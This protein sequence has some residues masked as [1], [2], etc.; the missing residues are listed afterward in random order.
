MHLCNLCLGRM[1]HPLMEFH[2]G[3]GVWSLVLHKDHKV[4]TLFSFKQIVKLFI[5]V[6]HFFLLKECSIISFYFNYNRNRKIIRYKTSDEKK[7]PKNNGGE[8]LFF[9]ASYLGNYNDD[10][11]CIVL[12]IDN[13]YNYL[14]CTKSIQYPI[15]Q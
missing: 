10:G 5:D 1:D 2:G 4:T 14:S 11:C 12:L 6:W 15:N 13:L 3:S 7:N 8:S 9:V